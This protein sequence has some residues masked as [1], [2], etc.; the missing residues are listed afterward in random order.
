MDIPRTIAEFLQQNTGVPSE[1]EPSRADIKDGHFI[2]SINGFWDLDGTWSHFSEN[3]ANGT[4]HSFEENGP[5]LAH[6]F[7]MTLPVRI[8]YRSRGTGEQWRGVVIQQTKKNAMFLHGSKLIPFLGGK[9]TGKAA[10]M[11]SN[12]IENFNE[13]NIDNTAVRGFVLNVERDARSDKLFEPVKDG[14]NNNINGYLA[15]QAFIGQITFEDATTT[16]DE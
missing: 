14:K 13:L 6:G 3:Y 7:Q 4:G 2:V 12:H 8:V 5:T 15:E 11:M 10:E 16:E 1:A 9:V